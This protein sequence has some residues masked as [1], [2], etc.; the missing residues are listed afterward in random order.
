MP[1]MIMNLTATSTMPTADVRL[2]DGVL[3]I[4]GEQKT[5]S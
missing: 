1:R 4:S 2:S 5:E 3:I